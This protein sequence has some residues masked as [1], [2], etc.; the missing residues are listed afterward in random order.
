MGDRHRGLGLGAAGLVSA[1]PPLAPVRV[2]GCR[3]QRGGQRRDRAECT[4]HD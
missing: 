1:P 4:H 3:R 2:L